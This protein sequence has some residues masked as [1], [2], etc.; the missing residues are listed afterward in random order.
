MSKDK[1]P[2]LELNGLQ[3][4]YRTGGVL[5]ENNLE[6]VLVLNWFY[7]SVAATFM[8]LRLVVFKSFSFN[9]FNLFVLVLYF[10][11]SALY[12]KKS[13]NLKL[14]GILLTTIF[15]FAIPARILLTGGLTSPIIILYLSHCAIVLNLYGNKAGVA[16]FVWSVL[17]IFLI[18]GVQRYIGLDGGEFYDSPINFA[19]S[20]VIFLAALALAALY[21]VRGKDALLGRLRKL[22]RARVS[23][24]FMSQLSE[25]TEDTVEKALVA[26][27]DLK[28]DEDFAKIDRVEVP[29]NELANTLKR[30][31]YRVEGQVGPQEKE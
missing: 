17:S 19:I 12:V 4:S 31:G 7:A 25:E 18:A 29:L 27:R 20:H 15:F 8:I 30:I 13:R 14:G 21:L 1:P 6:M 2:P 22:E 24:S 3:R 28:S 26:L 10:S 23:Y 9:I 5:F 11:L 16:V